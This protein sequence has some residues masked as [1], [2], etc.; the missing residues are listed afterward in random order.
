MNDLYVLG[1]L[2]LLMIFNSMFW[3]SQIGNPWWNK[4]KKKNKKE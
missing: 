3:G 2:I 4:W 1:V